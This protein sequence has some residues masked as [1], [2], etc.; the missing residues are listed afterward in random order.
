MSSAIYHKSPD[1]LDTREKMNVA[2]WTDKLLSLFEPMGS[3]DF[4]RH[5]YNAPCPG[6]PD[7]HPSFW[8]T[9]VESPEWKA[10]VASR[11]SYDIAECEEVGIISKKHFEDFLAHALAGR[12][13]RGSVDEKGIEKLLYLTFTASEQKIGGVRIKNLAH[14]IAERIGK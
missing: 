11:P 3:E 4:L 12:V 13:G 5:Y 6:C 14:A 10:W 9:V 2:D 8:K 1:L 7:G